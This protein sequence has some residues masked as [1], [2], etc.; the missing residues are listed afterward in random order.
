MRPALLRFALL[1]LRNRSLA[2]DV[3]QDALLA[4]LE[5]PEQF[6]GRSSLRTYAIGILKYKI[7]DIL[8]AAR[9]EIPIEAEDERPQDDVIDALFRANGHIHTMPNPWGDPE[10]ALAQKDFFRVLEI[11]S[12][13][14]STARSAS[15]FVQLI[16]AA[17]F[18]TKSILFAIKIDFA[19]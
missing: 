1:Q 5:K 9:R 3:V 17:T 14:A 18:S 13:I 16:V 6:G 10:Q 11:V 8:R 7:I 19:I 15:A 2:E 4:L 12:M